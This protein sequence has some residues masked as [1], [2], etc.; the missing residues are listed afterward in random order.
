LHF[1]KKLAGQSKFDH[2]PR[3]PFRAGTSPGELPDSF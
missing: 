2:R 3:L 1:Y